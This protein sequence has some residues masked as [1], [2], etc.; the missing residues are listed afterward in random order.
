MLSEFIKTI[1]KNIP[2]LV[3]VLIVI[4]FSV[5]QAV[6]LF[7]LPNLVL[8]NPS[9]DIITSEETVLVSGK[10]AKNTYLNINGKEIYLGEEGVF[11]EEIY[12]H[13]GINEIRVEA[14]NRLGKIKTIS[15]IITKE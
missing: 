1:F 5:F 14:K 6:Q 12:L 11:E 15:R 8:E 2:L 7:G 9:L 4:S 13:L 3:F 10:G